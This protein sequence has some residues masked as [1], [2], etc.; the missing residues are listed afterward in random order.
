MKAYLF[1]S[2][3][4]FGLIAILHLLRA[5]LEWPLVRTD[6]AAFFGMAALG[7]FAA[8]LSAWAWRLIRG[9]TGG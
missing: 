6:P 4:I 3:T 1:T 2:G 8:L 5:I 9:V 7:L